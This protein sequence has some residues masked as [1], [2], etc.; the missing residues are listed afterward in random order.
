[1]INNDAIPPVAPIVT[2]AP[3]FQQGYG[4][5]DTGANGP[6]SSGSSE[7]GQGPVVISEAPTDTGISTWWILD[8]GLILKQCNI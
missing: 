8:K 2:S 4:Y 6:E 1:M 7:F 3:P 5:T